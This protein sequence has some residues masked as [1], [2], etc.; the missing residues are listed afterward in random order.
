MGT[1]RVFK[2]GD[3]KEKHMYDTRISWCGM[4]IGRIFIIYF[5][6]F[7]FDKGRR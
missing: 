7:S 2:E 1:V 3:Q 5:R 6:F 4:K